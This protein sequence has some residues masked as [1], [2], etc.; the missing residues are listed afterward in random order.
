MKRAHF[1]IGGIKSRCTSEGCNCEASDTAPT[2]QGPD[3]TACIYSPTSPEW[4]T[5]P[6][7]A[8]TTQHDSTSSNSAS[9]TPGS[10]NL[11]VS[12]RAGRG[13]TPV[14]V[15]RPPLS[16]SSPFCSVGIPNNEPNTQLRADTLGPD[17]AAVFLDHSDELELAANVG[18]WQDVD[19]DT[20]LDSGCSRHVLPPSSVPGYQVRETQLSRSG[21][22]FT[23]ANGDPVPNLG[24]VVANLGLDAG[25]GGGRTVLS[26][27]AVCDMLS[28]LMSVAQ[29][30]KNGH[31][32]T[33]TKDHALVTSSDGEV[34]Q[35]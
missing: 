8:A 4:A 28:P 34:L 11:E 17:P 1:E 31:T 30:C 12:N 35:V 6:R 14:A 26:T 15:S 18:D 29:L 20:I 25:N 5:A 21:H 3:E 9:V 27:F 23:V 16:P 7:A 24:E 19:F 13:D 33:F 10:A 22:S 2:N 32:C